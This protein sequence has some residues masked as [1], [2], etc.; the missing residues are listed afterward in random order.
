[1]QITYATRAAPGLPNEDHVVA[2]PDWVVVVDGATAV[3]GLD[4]GCVHSVV[5][6][7]RNLAGALAVRLTTEPEADLRELL[8]AAIKTTCEAHAGSCDLTN[9]DSPSATLTMLRRRGDELDWLVLA[10]SPLVLD[11]NGRI[12]VIIDD[13]VARL[14]GYTVEAVRAARNDPDGFWV[15]GACPEAAYEAITGALPVTSVRR[16]GLFSDGASRLVELFGLLDWHGLLDELDGAGPVELIRRTR[17]AEQ[18]AIEAGRDLRRGKPYDD[19]TA[20][21]VTFER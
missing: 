16:A 8:A 18:A 2:G 13:R 1:M 5:W 12:E 14:P 21:L 3:P 20:A 11:V 17:A 19:A 4:T 6:L 9:P 10:D 15:A 7:V